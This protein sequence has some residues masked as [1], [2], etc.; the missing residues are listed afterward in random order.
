MILEPQAVVHVN[1]YSSARETYWPRVA[2]GAGSGAGGGA[3]A[4]AWE[5][6]AFDAT[7]VQ[8]PP[9]LR[10]QLRGYQLKVRCQQHV[11][12]N[13]AEGPGLTAGHGDVATPITLLNGISLAPPNS[14][15]AL[16]GPVTSCSPDSTV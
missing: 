3:A 15:A 6:M 13:C 4:E 16:S 9:A 11:C 8:P 7:D 12:Q 10:A 2:E 1:R 5:R 14:P